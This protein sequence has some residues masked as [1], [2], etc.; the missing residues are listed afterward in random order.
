LLEVK[1]LEGT[2]V[3]KKIAKVCRKKEDK[4]NQSYQLK[5]D[6]GIINSKAKLYTTE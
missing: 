1:S 2:I 4:S 5:S 6:T 3:E